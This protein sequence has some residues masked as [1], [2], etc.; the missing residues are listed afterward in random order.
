MNDQTHTAARCDSRDEGLT[1]SPL[2][3]QAD[4]CACGLYRLNVLPPPAPLTGSD[5]TPGGRQIQAPP[6]EADRLPSSTL[7]IPRAQ[8]GA[9]PVLQSASLATEDIGNVVLAAREVS[10]YHVVGS[11]QAER[12]KALELNLATFLT[13]IVCNCPPGSERVS[14]ISRAREA[15]F[16]GAAAIALEGK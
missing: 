9:L 6:I 14:A 5:A 8:T 7:G 11:D 4:R 15:K 3:G 10:G 2:A 13:A 1:R 12:L 16:W